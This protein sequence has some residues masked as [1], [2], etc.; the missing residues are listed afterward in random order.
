MRILVL[1]AGAIGG[2]FGGRLAAAGVDT[3]FLVRPKRAELLAQ[4]GL[5]VKSSLGDIAMPVKTVLREQVGPGYD[6]ILLSS[7]SYDLDDAIESLR[8]AVPGA[9]VIPLLNGML[10]LDRLDAGF[11]KASVGGGVAALFVTMEPDGTIRHQGAGQTFVYGERDP[12][13]A[14]RCE[15]LAPV[16]TKGGFEPRHSREIVQDM[17]EKFVFICSAMAMCCLMRGTVGEVAKTDDGAALMLEMLDDCGAVAA[18]AGYPQRPRHVEYTRKGLT[19]PA[20]PNAPSMLRD[21]RQG[22]QVEAQHVVGDRLARA[23][24]L[25]RP[26]TLLRAAYAHLQVYQAGRS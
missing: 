1:G 13:Q 16:L 18:A 24:A 20:S 25:G 19:D 4:T 22:F 6:A 3:T 7:K 5:R 8:P 2:Y 11:G 17:W 26:A 15:A 10:H 21:L 23:R 12:A 9:V 14:A